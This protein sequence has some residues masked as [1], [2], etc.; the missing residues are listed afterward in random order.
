MRCPSCGHPE[1]VTRICDEI[2]SYGG[3][4][5][6]LHEMKGDFCPECGEGV[7]AVES[8]RRFTEE[9]SKLLDNLLNCSRL[10]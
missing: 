9:Q 8:Y 3:K 1:M 6:I 7:W 5:V 2:L 10:S 4:S